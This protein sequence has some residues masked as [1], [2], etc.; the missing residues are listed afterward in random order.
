MTLNI[1][2]IYQDCHNGKINNVSMHAEFAYERG[3]FCL[4]SANPLI[5]VEFTRSVERLIN[6]GDILKE[7]Y[8]NCIVNHNCTEEVIDVSEWKSLA[9]QEYRACRYCEYSTRERTTDGPGPCDEYLS[10]TDPHKVEQILNTMFLYVKFQCTFEPHTS[11]RYQVVEAP[12]FSYYYSQSSTIKVSRED[13]DCQANQAIAVDYVVEQAPDL[14]YQVQATNERLVNQ[15]HDFLNTIK[16]ARNYFSATNADFSINGGYYWGSNDSGKKY[17]YCIFIF[18]RCQTLPPILLPTTNKL[19]YRAAAR[20]GKINFNNIT[21][22]K[23]MLAVASAIGAVI[24]VTVAIAI[25]FTIHSMKKG[26]RTPMI[27]TTQ[28]QNPILRL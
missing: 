10:E 12:V 26:K 11:D 22:E 17:P 1:S 16:P 5:P 3:A 4:L 23:T 18:Y 13:T 8:G 21:K 9:K 24:L 7:K 20:T 14:R 2:K 28:N 27:N 15:V 6:F 25:A 19:S